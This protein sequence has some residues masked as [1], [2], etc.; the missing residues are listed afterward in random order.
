[1]NV[2]SRYVDAHEDAG[3]IRTAIPKHTMPTTGQGLWLIL[4]LGISLTGGEP[5]VVAG[6]GGHADERVCA[7]LVGCGFGLL[8]VQ[9]CDGHQALHELHTHSPDQRFVRVA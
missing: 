8:A 4:L 5:Y 7:M 6:A 3:L 1:M 2:P 9:Q